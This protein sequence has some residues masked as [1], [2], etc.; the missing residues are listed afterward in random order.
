MKAA[1]AD[2]RL[3]LQKSLKAR[4]L[5]LP[6][7]ENFAL[8]QAKQRHSTKYKDKRISFQIQ[9]DMSVKLR[10]AYQAVRETTQQKSKLKKKLDSILRNE[11]SLKEKIYGQLDVEVENTKTFLRRKNENK[12]QHLEKK[13]IDRKDPNKVPDSIQR[14]ENI[15]LYDDFKVQGVINKATVSVIGDIELDEDE[16]E[17]LGLPPDFTVYSRLKEEEFMVET[18]MAM[19]K[20]RWEKR[21]LLEEQ[22][23]GEIEISDIEKEAMEISEAKSRSIFDPIE[24]T[25]DLRKR[26]VT[27]LKENSRVHLPRPLPAIEEA[28]IEIRRN[29]YEKVFSEYRVSQKKWYFVEKR[30]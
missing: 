19:T 23:D 25:L 5:G 24:K 7:V 13:Y 17:V 2:S 22:I 3:E 28:K 15:K 14:F 18:E 27:D 11:P 6:D 16:L 10:D 21:K 12:I 4:N 20:L 26:R 1:R 30:P 8:N 9:S 29:K